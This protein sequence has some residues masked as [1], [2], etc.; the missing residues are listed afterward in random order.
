MSHPNKPHIVPHAKWSA[1]KLLLWSCA[2]RDSM[3]MGLGT[4]PKEAYD[5]WRIRIT[6]SRFPPSELR[7]FLRPINRL[8]FGKD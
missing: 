6:V 2:Y 4:T 3:V 7:Q 1:K 5:N 8:I